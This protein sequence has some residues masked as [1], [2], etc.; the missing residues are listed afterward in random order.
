M[1]KEK[2]P[3]QIYKGN[4]R[5]AKIM[6]IMSPVVF[7]GL[8]ALSILCVVLAIRHSFGNIAEITTLLDDKVYTGE[9]IEANYHYLLEKYGEWT[10][11]SGGYGFTVRFINISHALFSGLMITNLILAV[12]FFISAFLLGKWLLPKIAKQINV[13]NQ[14]MVNITILKQSK[15]G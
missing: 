8:I 5:K 7:W 13:E 15:K 3:E 6:A 2:T 10:I 12:V 11:G 9:E 14:D 1:A 4:K